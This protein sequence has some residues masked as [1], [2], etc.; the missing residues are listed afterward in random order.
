MIRFLKKMPDYD[1]ELY[2]NKKQKSTTETSLEA[3]EFILPVLETIEKWQENTIHDS[4]MQAIANAGLKNGPILWPL[5]IAISG[6]M[7][8]PG[9]A[10]EIAYLLG[11][12]V[13]L[14]RIKQAIERLRA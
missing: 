2:V 5:R 6:Q 8:T 12:Q 10:I 3:L 9:G 4:V 13:T 14:S 7:S 1:N 11:K